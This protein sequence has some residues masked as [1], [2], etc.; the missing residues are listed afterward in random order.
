[1]SNNDPILILQMQRMGDL[2]LSFPLVG[3]LKS[4]HPDTPILVVAEKVFFDGLVEISPPVTYFSYADSRAL[5]NK[6]Y[7]LVINLSH[8]LEAAA[9][10]G[11]VRAEK[12]LGPYIE[13]DG[14]PRIAGA[15]QLYRASISHNNRHNLFHWADLNAM[16]VAPPISM[17]MTSWPPV[18]PAGSK[19]APRVGLFVGASERDKRPEPTFWAELAQKLMQG[20]ARPVFLGGEADKPLAGE[21]ARILKAPA[22]DLSGHFSI[23]Q[24]C[25]FIAELDLLIVPDTGP[26]HIAAWT[27]VP[28]LNLSIGPVNP[29]ETGPF[30]PGHYVLR[31]SLSCAGCWRCTQKSVLC[32]ERLKAGQAAII[33][34]EI[35]DGGAGLA[36]LSHL[37]GSAG[38]IY[39]TRRDAYGLFDM[40]ILNPQ[41]SPAAFTDD[42]HNPELRRAVGSFWKLFFGL[43]LGFI[44]REA[45][46][47][48]E[49]AA[50]HAALS[51]AGLDAALALAGRQMLTA[52]SRAIQGRSFKSGPDLKDEDFWL[53]FPPLARPLSSYIQFLLHNGDFS[54]PALARALELAEAFA[55]PPH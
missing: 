34:G 10:A 33:A 16:D 31:P 22:M 53:S 48:A 2:V 20:G 45:K 1:M 54:R 39:R 32:K 21:A 52:L 27:G 14:S 36:R 29:W 11:R 19:T 6:A 30:A 47:E 44:K 35:L 55:A 26:M 49:F 9:L 50:R 23:V 18:K 5:E 37:D 8:R 15:W 4:L 46:S 40:E 41:A 7:S 28:V 25:R 51:A 24:L 42:G 12:R 13:N 38:H 17:L 43:E 3:W